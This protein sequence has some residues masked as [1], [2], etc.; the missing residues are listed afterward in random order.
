MT[1]PSNNLISRLDIGPSISHTVR[2]CYLYHARTL[3][4]DF[5]PASRALPKPLVHGCAKTAKGVLTW[6]VLFG[7]F[8]HGASAQPDFSNPNTHF[9]SVD[10]PYVSRVSGTISGF[11][12]SAFGNNP[13]R[14]SILPR[15]SL[16]RDEIRVIDTDG[17]QVEFSSFNRGGVSSINI[18]VNHVGG[19]PGDL[20]G[21]VIAAS[22][23]DGIRLNG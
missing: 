13:A 10:N 8:S 12:T 21:A 2:R 5:F 20:T 23:V 1:L 4:Q 19:L 14:V 3:F 16:D 7:I 22:V 9:L 15:F 18:P 11:Y 17:I 6:A